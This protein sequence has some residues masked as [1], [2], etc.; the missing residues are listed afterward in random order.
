MYLG[1]GAGQGLQRLGPRCVRGQRLA[2]YRIFGSGSRFLQLF[3][4]GTGP[5]MHQD[6][7]GGRSAI[8]GPM[9]DVRTLRDQTKG[10]FS[11]GG[12]VQRHRARLG[13]GRK[14]V[15]GSTSVVHTSPCDRDSFARGDCGT[16]SP[17]WHGICENAIEL[18][19]SGG[20]PLTR[21]TPPTRS[22]AGGLSRAVA[23]GR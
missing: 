19:S 17:A 5:L 3:T 6:Q 16:W 1:D 23:A 20:P 8:S 13:E 4:L 10:I 21:H 15:S 18:C 9:P 2:H 7:G 11:P 12:R 14:N 22:D